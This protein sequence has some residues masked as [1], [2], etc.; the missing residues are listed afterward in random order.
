MG[1]LLCQYEWSHLS[2]EPGTGHLRGGCGRARL[3]LSS[4]FA[5]P[6]DTEQS[7]GLV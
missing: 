4:G 6:G 3:P 1:Q 7:R 2:S 5:P